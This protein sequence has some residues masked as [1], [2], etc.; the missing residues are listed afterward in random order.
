MKR[1]VAAAAIAFLSSGLGMAQTSPGPVSPA[2][3]PTADSTVLNLTPQSGTMVGQAPG[4][5]SA[6]PQDRIGRANAQY[7]TSPNASNSQDMRPLSK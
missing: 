5:N 4:A 1:L 6:N 3:S 2:P 7:R